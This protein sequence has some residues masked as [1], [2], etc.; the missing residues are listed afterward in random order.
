MVYS[1]GDRQL[2]CGT[3][4]WSGNGGPSKSFIVI[5][6]VLLSRKLLIIF[7]RMGGK[8]IC[9]ILYLSPLVHTLS[10]ALTTS[11]KTIQHCFLLASAVAMDS[12][13]VARAVSVDLSFLK[14][15][16]DVGS[17]LFIS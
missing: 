13:M 2:P 9:C 6:A 4:L 11:L 8:F 5:E 14:P 3:P 15:C 12:V 7:V 10:N 16:C 17:V 1:V